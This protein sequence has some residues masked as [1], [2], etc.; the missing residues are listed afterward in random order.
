MGLLSKRIMRLPILDARCDGWRDV[1]DGEDDL[2]VRATIPMT[3]SWMRLA[4]ESL[5][6]GAELRVMFYI[7]VPR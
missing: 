5:A 2:I 4:H 7:E 3:G 6:D 1:N